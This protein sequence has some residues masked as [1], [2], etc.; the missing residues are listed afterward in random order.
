[1]KIRKY[2]NEG[3]IEW[4]TIKADIVFLKKHKKSIIEIWGKDDWQ[5]AMDKLTKKG[6]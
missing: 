4:M 6:K 2:L 1:M 3:I 5:K